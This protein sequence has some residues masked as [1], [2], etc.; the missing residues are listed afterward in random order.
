MSTTQLSVRF[1]LK[2]N[3]HLLPNR[4]STM[5]FNGIENTLVSN[6]VNKK[7][8]KL[9]NYSSSSNNNSNNNKNS[10]SSNNDNKSSSRSNKNNGNFLVG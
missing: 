6:L 4:S 1:R 10:S 3:L 8:R 2:A 5:I 7:Q 9:A